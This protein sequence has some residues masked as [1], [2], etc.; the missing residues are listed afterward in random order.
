MELSINN[1]N[2]EKFRRENAANSDARRS[3]ALAIFAR[4]PVEGRVKTRLARAIGN[5]KACSFYE[6]MLRDT[7]R[8]A[9]TSGGN[10]T[11]ENGAQ[12][13]LCHAPEDAA[14]FENYAIRA[15]WK[16]PRL[17]QRGA[18]LGARMLNCCADLQ[19]RGFQ[20]TVIIGSDAPDIPAAFLRRAFG[21]LRR[22]DLTFGPASDGGFYLLGASCELPPELFANVTWSAPDTLA[23]TLEDARRLRLRVRLLP[24]WR[25]V[26]DFSDLVALRR[27]LLQS[28]SVAP[29]TLLWLRE[30]GFA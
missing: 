5:A 7:L 8:A 24:M 26:D 2:R 6:A 11:P 14:A 17:L 30:N 13:W 27:K 22:C 12:V 18:E 28:H 1:E 23:R 25:D 15:N 10:G 29:Q 20:R 21:E 4:A 16:E 9:R 3:C 19:A